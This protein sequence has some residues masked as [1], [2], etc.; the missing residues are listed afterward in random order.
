[1]ITAIAAGEL[2]IALLAYSSFALAIENG[3]MEDLR[4][5]ADD[6]QGN[7]PGY[8]EDGFLVLNDSPIK[9]ISDLKGKVLGISRGRDA[10]YVRLAKLLRER[11]YGTALVLPRTWKA[12]IF[13]IS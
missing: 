12:A 4:V 11:N 5:I 1:M 3:H 2:D 10:S 9:T 8:F 7:V 6:F 13:R